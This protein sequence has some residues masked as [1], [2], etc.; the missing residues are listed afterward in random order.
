[1]F[2]QS[3]SSACHRVPRQATIDRT[4]CF[5]STARAFAPSAF[6][7][8]ELLVVIG[9]IA[10]L[11]SILLPALSKA[12]ESATRVDC[13]SNLR[14]FGQA[15]QLYSV[16]NKGS[17]PYNGDAKPPW[18]PVGG[19]DLSWNSSIMQDEFFQKCLL[20]NKSIE[21][22][23]RNNILFCPTQDWHRLLTND[24]SLAGGLI[25][26]FILPH[27]LPRTQSAMNYSFAG[28]GWVEKQK[29]GGKYRMAPIMSDLLQYE[30]TARTWSQATSHIKNN[31][32]VGGNFLF[33]DGH[34]RFYDFG[35]VKKGAT[36]GSWECWYNVD[37]NWK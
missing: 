30:G 18:C 17:F 7:L 25:G 11:I 13:A 35:E 5:R 6:T 23:S 14:C 28:N 3:G 2:G 19:K 12:R 26:Y 27:R 32:P 16:T 24:P 1:M 9:I 10:V 29:V 36:L 31:A 8:V 34:V 33:E 37:L 21:Q 4:Q 22:R 15:F 20:K